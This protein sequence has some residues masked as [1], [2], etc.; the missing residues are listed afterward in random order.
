M[1]AT[2]MGSGAMIYIPSFIKIASATRKLQAYR[3]EI[4]ETYFREVGK[5][6]I[7]LFGL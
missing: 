1:Y 4:A 6:R 7:F 5:K 2:E 3:N